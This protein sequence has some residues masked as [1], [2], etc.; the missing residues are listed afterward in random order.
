[1]LTFFI[2][3]KGG[4][5]S[6]GTFSEG[7]SGLPSIA[8]KPFPSFWHSVPLWKACFPPSP[9]LHSAHSPPTCRPFPGDPRLH[10][11]GC[12]SHFLPVLA[13]SRLHHNWMRAER[14]RLE[15]GL[16]HGVP[17]SHPGTLPSPPETRVVLFPSVSYIGFPWWHL[18]LLSVPW[19]KEIKGSWL[20]LSLTRG[21]SE[22]N[23]EGWRPGA[24]SP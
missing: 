18:W 14:H 1:M 2:N 20:S 10:T 13:Q 11:P 22:K 3:Q 17:Q 21:A 16:A 12:R 4:D 6:P 24:K 9:S 7:T 8:Q 15:R 23:P 5:Q 19:P